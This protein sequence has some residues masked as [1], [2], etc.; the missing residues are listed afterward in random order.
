ME[1]L[2]TLL[3]SLRQGE[4]L[5]KLDLKD[6]YFFNSNTS[7]GSKIPEIPSFHP[8][9]EGANNISTPKGLQKCDLSRRLLSHKP[10]VAGMFE[11]VGDCLASGNAG[12]SNQLE[13]VISPSVPTGGV[14][15]VRSRHLSVD[16]IPTSGKNQQNQLCA[17]LVQRKQCSLWSLSSLIGKLQNAST[18][19][20]P[21][22]LHFRHMQMTSIRGLV[23]SF[24]N[25]AA[26][27]DLP[28][29]VLEELRWWSRNLRHWNGKSFVNPNPE[30]DV[31][32]MTDASKMGWGAHCQ[33]VT[34][35]G[36][37]SSIER[38]QHINV[39]ELRAAD[40]AI[41]AF[42]R[43]WQ[44][45][46]IR[47]VMDNTTAVSLITVMG[48]TRSS[49]CLVVTQEI[50]EYVLCHKSTITA[51][52]LPGKQNVLADYQSRVFRDNTNWMLSREIFQALQLLFPN[53]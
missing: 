21:G 3:N 32:I 6:A 4:S 2:G 42:T 24:Q 17:D 10:L 14:L 47:V 36:Q 25:Y 13:E 46:R 45:Q 51:Q 30:L 18:A 23:R 7:Q 33:G 5:S 40:L 52:F 44:G 22:P 41:R 20:L 1:G 48:S 8:F 53:I 29:S 43:R 12:L 37:W 26:S 19:I 50:W 34:T 38:D 39:L 9:N 11:N 16:D 27:V 28:E 31:V 15:G 35:Q 49:R